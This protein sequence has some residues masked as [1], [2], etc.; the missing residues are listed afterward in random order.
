MAQQIHVIRAQLERVHKT[1]RN[2][3]EQLGKLNSQLEM[4]KHETCESKLLHHPEPEAL[5]PC[6]IHN[7]HTDQPY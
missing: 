3:Q 2:Q 5:E 1:A 6:D 4:S 7:S